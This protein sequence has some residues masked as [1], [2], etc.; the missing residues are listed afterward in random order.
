MAGGLQDIPAFYTNNAKPTGRV[1]GWYID[2]LKQSVDQAYEESGGE[3]VILMA[4]SAGGWLARAAMSDGIWSTDVDS[5]SVIRTSDKIQC[6]VT[7]GWALST[8]FQRMNP[9]V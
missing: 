4:H 1:Y 6:L 2:R 8:R 7:L 5:E 3:K 9:H